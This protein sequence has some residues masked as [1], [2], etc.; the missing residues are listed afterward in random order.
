MDAVEQCRIYSVY[1]CTLQ[2]AECYLFA[3]GNAGICY[4]PL[5]FADF[6]QVSLFS[7][8]AEIVAI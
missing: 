4:I 7:F 8:C 6:V 3:G 1:F 5:I 2:D